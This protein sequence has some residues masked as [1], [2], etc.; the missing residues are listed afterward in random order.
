MSRATDIIERFGM[1]APLGGSIG[2]AP[3]ALPADLS[4]QILSLRREADK[5]ATHTGQVRVLINKSRFPRVAKYFD[6]V[7]AQLAKL[8]KTL[9]VKPRI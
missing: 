4:A 2:P 5:L 1:T 9:D 6:G 8:G 7:L 3:E